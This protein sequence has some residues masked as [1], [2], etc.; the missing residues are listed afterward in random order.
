M[1]R[2][3]L[4]A[5]LCLLLM[6]CSYNPFTSNNHTTGSV[7]GTA[8]GAAAGAGG[9]ALVTSSKPLILLGGVGGGM[10]GYYVTTLR[11]D[12]GGVIHT[13]GQVYH[14]VHSSKISHR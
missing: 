9:V 11:F 1:P 4:P 12:A 6:G 5:I 13:G 2:K 7:G 8:I 14:V 10:L 3:A